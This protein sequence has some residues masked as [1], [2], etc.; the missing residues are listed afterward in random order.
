MRRVTAPMLFVTGTEDF[1]DAACI[2]EYGYERVG[3]ERKDFQCFPGF[4]HT[5]LIMGKAV[6][7]KVY[8]AIVAWLDEVTG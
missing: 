6:D 3:S 7:E 8:P 1:A 5:D 2:R 4:G